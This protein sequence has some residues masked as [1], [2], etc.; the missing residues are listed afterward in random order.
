MRYIGELVRK[1]RK[2][3]ILVQRPTCRVA[4]MRHW[5]AAAIE[6]D[7]LLKA[8][9]L[10][11]V[12][13][14][15][16]NRGQFSLAVRDHCPRAAIIAFEP[17][18]SAADVYRTVFEHDK[19]VRL[20]ECAIGPAKGAVTIQRSKRE[21]SSSL[22]PITGTMVELF[23]GTGASGTEEVAI[24]PLTDFLMPA[25]IVGR[26]LL[27]IDVQGFELQVLM[28]AKPLLSSIERIYVEA[29][30]VPLYAGQALADEV[31]EFLQREGFRLVGVQNPT[32]HP[33]SGLL[34]QADMLFEN[35][36]L[37]VAQT[38]ASA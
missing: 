23:P 29:S 11:T 9:P 3:I 8:F 20:H 27:K 18:K 24:A 30:F 26:S 13:D 12:V 35:K 10:D 15:G 21:D 17:L 16:A 1:L 31:I 6:H 25:D 37:C 36:A 19:R 4:L 38:G 28:S 7:P 34:V 5:V 32:I 14:V 2:A 22:L 33:K